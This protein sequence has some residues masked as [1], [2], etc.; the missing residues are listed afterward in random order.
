[1][2]ITARLIESN[3][4]RLHQN[5]DDDWPPSWTFQTISLERVVRSTSCLI[6]SIV[7]TS[8]RTASAIR[9]AYL[10]VL[11]FLADQYVRAYATMLRLSVAVVCRLSVKRYVL[12]LNGAP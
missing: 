3:Y 2:S 1:M 5:Q 10:L 9:I 7:N 6:L 8:E 12:W 11:K 4:F